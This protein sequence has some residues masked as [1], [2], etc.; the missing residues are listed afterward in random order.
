MVIMNED[1]KNRKRHLMDLPVCRKDISQR[2]DY[3]TGNALAMV[4]PILGM[5]EQTRHHLYAKGAV[6]NVLSFLAHTDATDQFIKMFF[7]I[8]ESYASEILPYLKQ[9]NIPDSNIIV[10]NDYNA[11]CLSA[12][13]AAMFHPDL[14]HY[15]RLLFI[16]AD[17][18]VHRPSQSEPL[19]IFES[20][21][22]EWHRPFLWG[23]SPTGEEENWHPF[24]IEWRHYQDRL[25]EYWQRLSVL[26][27][28]P[29]DVVKQIFHIDDRT[30]PRANGWCVGFSRDIFWSSEFREFFEAAQD[31]LRQDE[32]IISAWVCKNGANPEMWNTPA[33]WTES[34]YDTTLEHTRI[35]HLSSDEHLYSDDT[36]THYQTWK[37]GWLT[38][39][40]GLTHV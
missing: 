12:K 23:A 31:V 15:E 18:W 26:V 27:G 21:H 3:P 35:Y 8:G 38:E 7:A 34:Y 36:S 28:A 11:D 10:F 2:F 4:V 30:I 13:H 6:Y 5:P 32:A 14:Q 17:I 37:D 16:D 29:V 1:M 33:F 25:D 20:L 24:D 19:R 22:E 39:M 9:A 40:E